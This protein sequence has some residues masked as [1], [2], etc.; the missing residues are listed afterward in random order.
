MLLIVV[1]GW[2]FSLFECVCP[3]ISWSP[4]LAVL[5]FLLPYVSVSMGSSSPLLVVLGL[6][7]AWEGVSPDCLCPFL[8]YCKSSFSLAFSFL[9]LEWFRVREFLVPV[10]VLGNA[11]V[12]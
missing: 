8:V 5:G 4:L 9:P 7:L 1:G 2:E 12:F 11:C 3:W 6:L 10:L